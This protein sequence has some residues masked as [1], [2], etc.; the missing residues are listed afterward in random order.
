MFKNRELT[1]FYTNKKA[2]IKADTASM[3]HDESDTLLAHSR[4]SLDDEM[5]ALTYT[6]LT[7]Q[8]ANFE[9]VP[10]GSTCQ[11]LALLEDTTNTM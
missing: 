5:E 2:H 8:R 7:N 3:I 9:V 6:P 11:Y 10:A 1:V 4:C